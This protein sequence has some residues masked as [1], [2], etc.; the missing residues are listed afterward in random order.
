MS[1]YDN[2]LIDSDLDAFKNSGVIQTASITFS[3]N[4]AAG[5]QVDRTSTPFSLAEADL[6][7]ILFD[8]SAKHSG[9][10]KNLQLVP[11]TMV[12]ENTF[13]SELGVDLR[14][15]VSNGQIYVVGSLFNPYSSV[16]AL[17]STTINFRFIPFEATF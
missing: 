2:S 12:L 13:A 16:I 10:F 14:T 15:V 1:Q 9:K 11:F 5:A 17:Q 6:A 7:Q 3:G 8:N 4:V